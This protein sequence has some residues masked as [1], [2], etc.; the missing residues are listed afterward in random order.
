M[1]FYQ[2]SKR[3]T[4]VVTFITV[5]DQYRRGTLYTCFKKIKTH[6]AHFLIY[7]FS[8]AQHSLSHVHIAAPQ[9][10]RVWGDFP[11]VDPPPQMWISAAL[12]SLLHCQPCPHC[13]GSE[14][15][16]SL[17][18]LGW[19]PNHHP[20]DCLIPLHL[21]FS[22][23]S[24]PFPFLGPTYP[25]GREGG[26]VTSWLSLLFGFFST[27]LWEGDTHTHKCMPQQ[28]PHPIK[29]SRKDWS[30]PHFFRQDKF[31]GFVYLCTLNIMKA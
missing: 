28:Y 31:I 18:G 17:S 5:T 1:D 14:V 26:W 30:S 25:Q 9:S 27:H 15:Q 2:T 21:T 8:I 19:S 20:V 29:V 13:C 7:A 12:S 16:D 10:Y 3:G 22:L 23:S 4:L 11:A 6:P 24:S